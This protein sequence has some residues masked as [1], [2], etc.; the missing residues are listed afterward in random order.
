VPEI[1]TVSFRQA[2]TAYPKAVGRRHRLVRRDA[3]GSMA[4]GLCSEQLLLF[5]ALARAARR[6][7]TL[8]WNCR[9]GAWWPGAEAP[10]AAGPDGGA[11]LASLHQ[12]RASGAPRCC[13]PCEAGSQFSG[14]TL[15]ALSWK[16]RRKTTR[17]RRSNMGM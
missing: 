2:R 9:A 6:H 1:S 17:L 10:R 14:R 16:E 13:S 12:D 11:P 8:R 5:V 3:S 15:S 4:N 7:L